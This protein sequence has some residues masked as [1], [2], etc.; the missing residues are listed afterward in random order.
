MVKMTQEVS[1]IRSNPNEQIIHAATVLN[2][3]EPRKKIFSAIYRGKSKI[4]T[5]SELHILTGMTNVRVLQEGRKLADNEIVKQVKYKGETGYEKVRFYS[6]NKAKILSLAGNKRKM[7]KV[8]TKQTPKVSSIITVNLPKKQVDTKQ[9]TIDDISSFSKVKSKVA[10]SDNSL[11]LEKD[12]KD[13]FKSVLGEYGQFQDW[14]GEKDDLFS[15]RVIIGSRRVPTAIAF[16]GRG[17]K[18]KL[19]Q[20]K[21]ERM[22]TKFK[23]FSA[24]QQR[25]L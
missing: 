8:P 11:L 15:T 7:S 16:K 3:S 17:T 2:R 23:D 12:V 25:R 19:V 9:I 4:K 22:E 24:A 21:W 20:E 10:S 1:D 5:V 6:Q 14:G 18:G 13:G